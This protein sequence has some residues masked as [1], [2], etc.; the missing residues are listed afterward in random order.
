VPDLVTDGVLF[1]IAAVVSA[2][3]WRGVTGAVLLNRRRR[4]EYR[5]TLEA[6]DDSCIGVLRRWRPKRKNKA[7]ERN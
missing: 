3:L 1:V 4:V 7:D 5:S 6:D 2:A